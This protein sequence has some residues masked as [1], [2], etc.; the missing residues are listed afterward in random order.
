MLYITV[1]MRAV[2]PN[3]ALSMSP[4]TDIA[5]IFSRIR[6]MPAQWRVIGTKW[7]GAEKPEEIDT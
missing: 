1:F 4:L 7:M 6:G 5:S 2:V 3:L